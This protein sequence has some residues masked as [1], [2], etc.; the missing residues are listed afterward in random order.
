MIS[1]TRASL[2]VLAQFHKEEI[3]EMAVRV[4]IKDYAGLFIILI[5]I[6]FIFVVIFS[7]VVNTVCLQNNTGSCS[8]R[9]VH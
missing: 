7:I 5:L 3:L 1:S 9:C 8:T 2:D 4:I 6:L